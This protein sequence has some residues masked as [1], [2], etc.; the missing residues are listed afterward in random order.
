M[1]F[2][3]LFLFFGTKK[4]QNNQRQ[5]FRSYIGGTE[6]TVDGNRVFRRFARHLSAVQVSLK[7]ICKCFDAKIQLYVQ[8][9]TLIQIKTCFNFESWLKRLHRFIL[10]LNN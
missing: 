3:F 4:D 7:I 10:R 6:F 5:T 1:N 2:I 9:N 8:F